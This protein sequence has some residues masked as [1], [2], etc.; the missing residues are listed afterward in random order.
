MFPGFMRVFF[1]K[2]GIENLRFKPAYNPYTEV[3]FLDG[4]S[5]IKYTDHTFFSLLL[6]FLRSILSCASG[7]KSVTVVCFALRCWSRWASPKTYMFMG[8]VLV[9][10]GQL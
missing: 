5:V 7:S 2:M 8:G 4:L 9:S 1:K 10:S 3:I 6:R